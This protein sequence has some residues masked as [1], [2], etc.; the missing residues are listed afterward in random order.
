M[1][2]K[3][4]QLC[5]SIKMAKT[6]NQRPKSYELEV[7][8]VRDVMKKFNSKLCTDEALKKVAEELKFSVRHKSRKNHLRG[9]MIA[10]L[11]QWD[12]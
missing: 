11:S 1:C 2:V 7:R 12:E 8:K 3:L 6:S 5:A 4:V 9:K 10:S